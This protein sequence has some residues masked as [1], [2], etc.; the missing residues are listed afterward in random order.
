MC[1]DR[2]SFLEES[3][4]SARYLQRLYDYT[5]ATTL[6]TTTKNLIVNAMKFV[7]HWPWDGVTANENELRSR[8][9]REA[10]MEMPR[11][12]T[13]FWILTSVRSVFITVDGAS[14]VCDEHAQVCE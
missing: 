1:A 10:V 6:E 12:A 4:T 8:K 2:H 14:S 13:R 7:T 3:E 5:Y 11:S 9:R